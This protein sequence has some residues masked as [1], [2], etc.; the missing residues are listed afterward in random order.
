M[1][2]SLSPIFFTLQVHFVLP[3][4]LYLFFSNSFCFHIILPDEALQNI[5][6]LNLSQCS[7]CSLP[8]QLTS[9]EFQC[10]GCAPC[11]RGFAGIV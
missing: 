4:L 10:P 8:A 7:W 3:W 11:V 6:F 1:Y 5:L 9:V 2:H